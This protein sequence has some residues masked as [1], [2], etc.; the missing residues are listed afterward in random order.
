[1]MIFL[2]VSDEFLNAC[3]HEWSDFAYSTT[4]FREEIPIEMILSFFHIH[5][6][7]KLFFISLTRLIWIKKG[8]G[9]WSLEIFPRDA[10][11]LSKRIL[12]ASSFGKRR[13][14]DDGAVESRSINF[15]GIRSEAPE[16]LIDITNWIN[17]FSSDGKF[18]FSFLLFLPQRSSAATWERSSL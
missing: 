18:I 12:R 9:R 2:F 6:C 17:L 10:L 11:I 7:E 16:T 14:D 3:S 1:M 5:T 15:T 13:I 8:Q 4:I